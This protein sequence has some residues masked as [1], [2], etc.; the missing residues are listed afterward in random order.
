MIIESSMHVCLMYELNV[1]NGLHR[2]E[3]NTYDP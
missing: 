2:L 3:L 1:N